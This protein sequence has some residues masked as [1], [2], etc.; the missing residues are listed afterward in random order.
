[1]SLPDE[2]VQP[3]T[4]RR[5]LRR[6]R[7]PRAP[8]PPLSAPLAVAR[9]VAVAVGLLALWVVGYALG[10]SAVQ[11]QR[12]QQQMYAQFREALTPAKGA[13]IGGAIARGTPVALMKAPAI[14]LRDV[15]VVQ[16]TASGDLRK[17]PGHRRDTP[18]PGQPG[19]SVLMGRSV[20]Y[21]APF[22]A[23][24]KLSAGDTLTF[25]TGQGR[26]T[27]Q[28]MDVR[29]A[30][31]P[32]PIQMGAGESRVVLVTS[33]GSGWQSGWAPDH[34]VYVDAKL[35][36]ADT[37]SGSA[38]ATPVPAPPGS[39]AVVPPDEQVMHGDTSALF[40]LVLW[41]QALVLVALGYGW[42]R[43]RWGRW[44]I[45]LVSVPIVVAVVW[46]ATDCAMEL[47]PNLL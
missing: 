10:P 23:I 43:G 14:G 15:M 45:W 32:L 28:V 22:R 3:P 24:A 47:L 12:S 37:G 44:Q 2:A 9:W 41:L 18:L 40:P 5:S 7:A 1:M 8:L 4:R 33:D 19:V 36:V 30:G 46:G 20:A 29:R 31:D 6:P 39:P 11:E 34:V 25:R 38:S 16:G 13:A 35:V 17:G 26:F 27:Y 21:G 42:G